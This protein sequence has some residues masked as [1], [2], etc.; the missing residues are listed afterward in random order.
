MPRE[1]PV[2]HLPPTLRD[3]ENRSRKPD[4]LARLAYLTLSRNTK[5]SGAMSRGCSS[6]VGASAVERAGEVQLSGPIGFVAGQKSA[7]S[8]G[9]LDH[10]EVST[11]SGLRWRATR[12]HSPRNTN[13]AISR[14]RRLLSFYFFCSKTFFLT[15]FL[16]STYNV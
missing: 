16:F 1:A 4:I 10:Y 9:K 11:E 15:I 6:C 7:L 14:Q 8:T 12:H 2:R 13:M 3:R 5:H